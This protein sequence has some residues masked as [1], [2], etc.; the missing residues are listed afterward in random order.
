MDSSAGAETTYTAMSWFVLAMITH[1]EIQ[2]RAQAELN[3]VVGRS[4]TLLFRMLQVSPMY[5]Q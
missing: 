3:A 1:P 4:R 2:R 5:R